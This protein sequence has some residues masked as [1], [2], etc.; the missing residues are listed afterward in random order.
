MSAGTSTV[1]AVAAGK[2]VIDGGAT[3]TIAS[4][5]ALEALMNKNKAKYGTDRIVEVN[6]HDRPVFGFG[7]SSTDRCMSTAQVGLTASGNPGTLKVHTLDRGTG[8]ILLSVESLRQ[9][10]AVIDFDA[11]L[12]VFRNINANRIVQL[13]RSA[14]GHQLLSL[15]EDLFEHSVASRDA[16]PS[17]RSFI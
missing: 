13:E 15:T 16:V 5:A 2:A 1:Q 3:K 14:T 6:V 11:D 4:V 10:G 8:P 9:L 17:L 7:N 12:A